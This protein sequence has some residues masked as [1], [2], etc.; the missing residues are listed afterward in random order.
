MDSA[1]GGNVDASQSDGDLE[2]DS[3][4][5]TSD[6]APTIAERYSLSPQGMYIPGRYA[7]GMYSSRIGAF[8]ASYQVKPPPKVRE[9]RNPFVL[10][11]YLKSTG[12]ANVYQP[13]GYVMPKN[14]AGDNVADNTTISLIQFGI[15]DPVDAAFSTQKP[16][17][18][19]KVS[20]SDKPAD[21]GRLL[22]ED[23]LRR[24]SLHVSKGR[25]DQYDYG[26]ES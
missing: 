23:D 1:D 26:T 9:R 21:P 11:T 3:L 5:S 19:R 10:E 25:K 2:Q 4:T 16:Q 14:M 24:R 7:P 6:L 15:G 8:I 20:D 17:V 18:D 13:T 12:A 22:E